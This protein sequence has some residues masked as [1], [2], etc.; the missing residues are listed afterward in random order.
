MLR[1]DIIP[2]WY[3]LS[4]REIEFAIVLRV[5]KDFIASQQ[6]PVPFEAPIVQALTEYCRLKFFNGDLNG[7]FGFENVLRRGERDDFVEFSAEIP[8]IKK[9]GKKCD[10]CGGEGKDELLDGECLFCHGTGKEIVY[11]N[12]L[13]YAIAASLCVFFHL[14]ALPPDKDTSCQASQLLTVN[15]IIQGDM[16]GCSM[17]GDFSVPL[18]NWLGS[19]WNGSDVRIPEMVGAMEAAYA[20]MF[21]DLDIVDQYYF[22]SYVHN[23]E[24]WLNV[25]CPGNACGLNPAS[26]SSWGERGYEFASHNLDSVGQQLTLLVGLAALHDKARKEMK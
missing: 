15:T 10:Y 11:D 12:Y 14:A 1:W 4:W 3:E 5:H 2:C 9:Q 19:L 17:G 20:K 16:N 8:R 13:S 7:S 18:R 26:P 6:N 24:G 25:S 22:G 23:R 21:V